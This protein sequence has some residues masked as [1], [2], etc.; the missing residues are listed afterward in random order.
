MKLFPAFRLVGGRRLAALTASTLLLVTIAPSLQAGPATEPVQSEGTGTIIGRLVWANG[1]VP[2]P[3]VIVKKDDP[4]VKDPFCKSVEL[5]S[6]ELV[7]DPKTKGVADAFAYLV[8]PSGDFSAV[9]KALLAK[10]PAV[11]VD[12]VGCEYVPYAT[13]VHKDQKLTF[14]SSD[15]V[16]HNVEFKP[17]NNPSMNPMLPPN[18]KV[19]YVIKKA[20]SRPTQAL[21]SIHPWMK[22][23]VFIVDN[24]FAVVTKT[25]GSFEITGIPP[26]VQNL[27]V[28]LPSKGYITANQKKGIPVTVTAGKITDV[29]LI[30]ITK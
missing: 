28:N 14:K 26:G 5:L 17:F 4:T 22:G 3:K 25:D 19:D 9:E 20:E 13:V 24:P 21:C 23:Y 27:I 10:T 2:V 16:G 11:V 15:P 30:Q 6:K 18:G 7:V 29:G 1:P 12:Q 8:N